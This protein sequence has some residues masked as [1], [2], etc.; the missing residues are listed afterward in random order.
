[1]NFAHSENFLNK[2][3]FISIFEDRSLTYGN[4]RFYD[5]NYNYMRLNGNK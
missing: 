2:L 5:N 4:M 1:M 3:F